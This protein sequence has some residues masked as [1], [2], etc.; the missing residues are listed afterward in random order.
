MTVIGKVIV[1]TRDSK[2]RFVVELFMC[3]SSE[4]FPV[5]REFYHSPDE[6]FGFI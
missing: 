3:V 2:V 4:V 5:R 6:I 1:H